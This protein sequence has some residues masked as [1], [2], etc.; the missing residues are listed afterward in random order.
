MFISRQKRV[1]DDGAAAAGVF[2]LG[3]NIP[4]LQQASKL[5]FER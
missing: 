3:T 5:F 4:A 2:Y 1:K